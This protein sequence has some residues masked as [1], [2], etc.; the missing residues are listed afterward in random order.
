MQVIR[1]GWLTLHNIGFLK[2]GSK[3]LWFVLTA[4]T[5]SW[6]SD[7]TEKEKKYMLPLE[8]LKLRDVEGGIFGKKFIFSIFNV[9]GKNV[10][11][12]YKQLELSCA[13]TEQMDEWKASFLRAGVYPDRAEE[14]NV[15]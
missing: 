10:F 6:F 13:N 7:D 2:G 9:E 15:S 5:L 1:K 12:E 14:T 3:G 8:G 11:K 4:E